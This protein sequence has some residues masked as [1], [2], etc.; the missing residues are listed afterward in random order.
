MTGTDGAGNVGSL[1][2]SA[3][4][5][6]FFHDSRRNSTAA[7]NSGGAP[8]FARLAPVAHPPLQ[9]ITIGF[10]GLKFLAIS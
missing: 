3:E 7:Q 9:G 8:G 10:Q 1:T 5:G 4:R 2:L 6:I